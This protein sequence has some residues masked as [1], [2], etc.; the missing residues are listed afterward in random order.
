MR[1]L[2]DSEVAAFR[3]DGVVHIRDAVDPE[4]VAAILESVEDLIDSHGR[5]GG[6]M[7]PDN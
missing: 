4:L 6:S 2:N 5:F 7:T 3:S 1:V